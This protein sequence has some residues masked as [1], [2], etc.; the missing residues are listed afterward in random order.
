VL[1][2]DVSDRAFPGR[3]LERLAGRPIGALVHTAGLSPTMADAAR[4]LAVN[5]DASVRLTDAILP[6]MAE[7]ACAVL[8]ASSSGYD[9]KALGYDDA[10]SALGAA[11]DASPLL[12][13]ATNSGFAYMLSKRGV[14]MLV[15][16]MA[17]AF[18]ARG[19]RIMSISPGLIDTAMGRAE[20]KA[21]PNMDVML[22][23]TPLGRY[24]TAEE[25]ATVATFLCSPAASFVSGSDIKVDGGV[26][27][28]LFG[29]AA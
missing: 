3:L 28:V 24:G 9:A 1:A 5:Y 6:H 16:R 2:G 22:Q 15:E 4:V 19:A 20:Q 29:A 21:H 17:P 7:G 8:I 26:L 18:G 12:D 13:I 10:I 25:I 11:D 23:K 27:A 14:Q